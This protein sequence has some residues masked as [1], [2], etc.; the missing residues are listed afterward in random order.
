M[1][2]F[3]TLIVTFCIGVVI[4]AAFFSEDAVTSS[5]V[6]VDREALT[7]SLSGILGTS[8]EVASTIVEDIKPVLSQMSTLS[9]EQLQ[10]YFSSLASKY[11]I[12][13]LTGGQLE[14]LLSLYHSLSDMDLETIQGMAQKTTETVSNGMKIVHAVQRIARVTAEFIQ[15]VQGA[16]QQPQH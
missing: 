6:A 8:Q 5:G 10:S 15:S 13:A 16:L 12:P 2:R 9:D 3:F 11:N 7:Q 14:G 1:K 4:G